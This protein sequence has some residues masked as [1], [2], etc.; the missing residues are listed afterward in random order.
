MKKLVDVNN[1]SYSYGKHKVLEK[2]SLCVEKKD[3]VVIIGP[4]GAGKSTLIKLLLGELQTT[5]G[6]ISLFNQDVN[7]FNNWYRLGYVA[8]N[9]SSLINGFPATVKEIVKLNLYHDIGLFKFSKKQHIQK[10]MDTLKKVGMLNYANNMISN[11]S[12]GQQQKVMLARV[13]VNNP[14]LMILDEP[15]NAIDQSSV[16]SLYELLAKLNREDDLTIIMITHDL[17]GALEY[18]NKFYC[19]EC[20]T[21]VE[22]TRQQ[23]LDELKNKHTHDSKDEEV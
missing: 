13:L 21:I 18:A 14:E 4:N 19:L 9:S 1:V 16:K 11:L 7:L 20:G 3:F 15:T 2:I 8:Q 6:E 22:L 12:G 17:E 5:Q 10:T 23:I